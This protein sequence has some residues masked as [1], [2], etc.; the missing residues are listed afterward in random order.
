MKIALKY[1]LLITLGIIA[2]TLT[3]HWVVPNPLSKV[4]SL[5]AVA[6]FNMVEIVGIYLGI[7]ATKNSNGGQLA[8]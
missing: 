6:F 8:F 5:G 1:G 3:A 2:W 7:Q 4:H